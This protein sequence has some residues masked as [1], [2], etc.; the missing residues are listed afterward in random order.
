MRTWLI[1]LLVL[2]SSC[3]TELL[4]LEDG[5]VAVSDGVPVDLDADLPPSS[6]PT[7]PT[8]SLLGSPCTIEGQVCV[9]PSAS[10]QAASAHDAWRCQY[11][12][13]LMIAQCADSSGCPQ[14]PSSEQQCDEDGRDCFYSSPAACTTSSILQCSG[15]WWPMNECRGAARVACDHLLATVPAGRRLLQADANHSV[16]HPDLA[17]A[18][19]QLLVAYRTSSSTTSEAA[20][21]L[22]AH[23]VQ[24]SRPVS[25]LPAQPQAGM[26]IGSNTISRPRVAFAVDR[27][28]FA[29]AQRT[30]DIPGAPPRIVAA[31]WPAAGSPPW[32]HL[33]DEDGID[34]DGREPTALAL[35][36]AAD[37]ADRPFGWI[38][39][40]LPI[41][42]TDEVK[43][44]A[45]V[46]AFGVD[47]EPIASTRIDVATE[48]TSP[49]FQAEVPHAT[50]QIIPWGDG[51]AAAA[52]IGETGD[53]Y[54]TRGLIVAFSDTEGNFDL[55]L[56]TRA[57][58]LP[59]IPLDLSLAALEDGSIVVAFADTRPDLS[60]VFFR[61]WRVR[62]G[63][64]PTELPSSMSASPHL[65]AGPVLASFEGG[66]AMAS[67]GLGDDGEGALEVKLLDL[68]GDSRTAM[69]V[70]GLAVHPSSLLPFIYGTTDR[71]LVVA[72]EDPPA[73]NGSRAISW[74]R[75]V[76]AVATK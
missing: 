3:R 54:S 6:C 46:V 62:P 69:T 32:L 42:E 1:A 20:M 27:Y 24:T 30:S 34:A 45:R 10:C 68:N 26:A 52:P 36:N 66:F 4:E 33:I 9:Y 31:S 76:C 5:S 2:P 18:G 16:R 40:R 60:A 17:L 49:P 63:E 12:R 56:S 64:D 14:E 61:L 51:F 72:W 58:N 13:W 70:S 8:P 48:V 39:Y 23:Q 7:S 75:F 29:W 43:A 37:L 25:V 19:T 67:L 15:R 65:V 28:L 35:S 55:P 59:F 44:L 11:S 38:G 73:E 21:G 50:V 41:V 47:H 74:Q 71:A 57:I 22:Y 53:L